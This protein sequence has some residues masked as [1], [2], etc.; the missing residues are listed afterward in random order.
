LAEEVIRVE[1]AT[2]NNPP[3]L[4][5]VVLERLVTGSLESLAFSTLDEIASRVR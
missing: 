3:D 4:I 1:T 2:K 5:N